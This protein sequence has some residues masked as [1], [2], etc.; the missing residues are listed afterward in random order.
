VSDIAVI[1]A[2]VFRSLALLVW[3]TRGSGTV[4]SVEISTTF[5]QR[6]GEGGDLFHTINLTG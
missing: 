4:H 5:G 1:P 2:E 6:D 3:D